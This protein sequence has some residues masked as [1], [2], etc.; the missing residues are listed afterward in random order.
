MNITVLSGRL[1]K[2]PVVNGSGENKAVK[3][4]LA[5]RYGYDPEEKKERVDFVP[6]VAFNLS[7]A[8][9]GVLKKGTRLGLKGRV[10]TSRFTS[11]GETKWSTEVVVDPTSIELLGQPKKTGS[12]EEGA[13]VKTEEDI[14]SE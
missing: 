3:F 12:Q 9:I 1:T 2:A 13:D 10:S 8:M 7:D 6:C 5:C 11:G 14:S 4:T